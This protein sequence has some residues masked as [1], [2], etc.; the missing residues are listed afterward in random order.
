MSLSPSVIFQVTGGSNTLSGIT[1]S[2]P[3]ASTSVTSIEVVVPTSTTH[4]SYALALTQ[5]EIEELFV[6][7][8]VSCFI[9]VNSTS[10]ATQ[11][12][13]FQPNSPMTW[14]RGMPSTCPLTA[15]V[16]V[17]FITNPSTSATLTLRGVA[18]QSL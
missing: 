9:F 18:G 17:F 14:V 12:F 4:Q 16:T 11:S 15:N 3:T 10:S 6:Y 1:A 8:D 13:I 5:V 7:S 2:S